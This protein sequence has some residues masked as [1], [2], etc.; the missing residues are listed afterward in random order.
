MVTGCNMG[1]E[2]FRL[3]G[4]EPKLRNLSRNIFIEVLANDQVHEYL[5][6]MQVCI[7]R[8]TLKINCKYI[9]VYV[10]MAIYN[11]VNLR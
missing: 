11:T 6:Q 8:I 2:K 5:W 10:S 4:R 3:W 1:S 7:A 9:N